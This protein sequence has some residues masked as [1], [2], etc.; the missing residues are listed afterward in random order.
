MNNDRIQVCAEWLW[1]RPIRAIAFGFGAG[2]APTAP[3][4]VGTLWAWAL[5]LVANIFFPELDT[6]TLLGLLLAGFVLGVWACGHAGNDLGQP[7]HGG[8]V[9]D[10]MIAFWLILV[11]IMPT[12]FLNQFI[13]FL[14]FRFF[15]AVK[16]GPIHSIDNFFKHWRPNS[17]TQERFATHVRGFGVMIDDLAAAFFTI[18]FYAILVRVH[19][20]SA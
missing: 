18:V 12:G 2:L 5:A 16:P 9:W 6:L 17:E 4:T 14:L 11:F 3:G 13:A 20:I 19:L 10:E 7:D 8:M 1:E 15:D